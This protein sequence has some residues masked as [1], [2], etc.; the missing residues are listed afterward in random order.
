[1]SLYL[2]ALQQL[3]FHADSGWRR[4]VTFTLRPF[5]SLKKAHSGLWMGDSDGNR[6]RLDSVESKKLG[7]LSSR[8]TVH[9]PNT[10]TVCTIHIVPIF[11][12]SNVVKAHSLFAVFVRVYVYVTNSFSG[13]RKIC[14]DC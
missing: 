8:V 11:K 1:M 12:Y 6:F 10:I 2:H 7:N 3:A 14:I 13:P 4:V 5:A 9:R